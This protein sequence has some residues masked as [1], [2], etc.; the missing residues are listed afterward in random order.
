MTLRTKLLL[1]LVSLL[2]VGLVTAD[3]VTY[4]QLRSFLFARIDPQLQVAS[5]LVAHN[6]EFTNNLLPARGGPRTGASLPAGSGPPSSR[7]FV[8]PSGFGST[9]RLS[10]LAPTGTYGEL[11]QQSGKP[12][13]T[14]LQSVYGSRAPPA[15]RLPR[16]LP[17]DTSGQGAIFTAESA[18]T[19]KIS[20][21]VLVR[22]IPYGSRV[23]WLPFP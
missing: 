14:V 20:Y 3:V 21:R 1:A 23:R 7:P 12:Y 4:T 16:P 18:G 9:R 22:K 10:D 15:P 19:D 8:R 17:H 2:T 6:L 11:V 13:G 5:V